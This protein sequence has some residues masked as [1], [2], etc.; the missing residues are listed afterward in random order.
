M[1]QRRSVRTYDGRLISDEDRQKPF[2]TE[3]PHLQVPAE[4]VYIASYR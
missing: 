4:W 3:D 1:N 2:G